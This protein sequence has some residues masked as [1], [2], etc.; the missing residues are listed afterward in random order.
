MR[1][2]GMKYGFFGEPLF[3]IFQLGMMV[4]PVK[5]FLWSSVNEKAGRDR[6][7]FGF[8]YGLSEVREHR[9]TIALLDKIGGMDIFKREGEFRLLKYRPLS[10]GLDPS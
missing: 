1:W 6:V 2:N 3:L 8:G 4:A 10:S 7:D 9:L 5:N